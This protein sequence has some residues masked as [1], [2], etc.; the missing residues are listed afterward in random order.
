MAC[1]AW[2]ASGRHLATADGAD[3]TVWDLSEPGGADRACSIACCGHE[4]RTAITALA[5]QPDG[6]LLVRAAPAL[7]GM[8][9]QGKLRW[10][11]PAAC[12]GGRDAAVWT[13]LWLRAWWVHGAQA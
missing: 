12:A 1:L 7:P 3:C 8:P 6:H 2:D 5:F 13:C 10:A 9:A 11:A 4:P